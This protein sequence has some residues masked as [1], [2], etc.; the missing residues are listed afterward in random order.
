M[1]KGAGGESVIKGPF[2]SFQG[3]WNVEESPQHRL[4]LFMRRSAAPVLPGPLTL[5]A[6]YASI[7]RPSAYSNT[8]PGSEPGGGRGTPGLPVVS[9]VCSLSSVADLHRCEAASR[10]KE[11]RIL[12]RF[13]WK[14]ACYITVWIYALLETWRGGACNPMIERKWEIGQPSA[15]H[16]GKWPLRRYKCFTTALSNL[17]NESLWN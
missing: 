1:M 5:H 17:Q 8:P 2:S 9:A 4:P 3:I 11:E 14:L 15:S 13:M 12:Q 10:D 16:G 7:H 6:I